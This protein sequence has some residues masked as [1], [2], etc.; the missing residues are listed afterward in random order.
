M[1]PSRTNLIGYSEY[2]N[3]SGWVIVSSGTI[4]DNVDTSPEGVVN[5]FS[6]ETTTFGALRYN[7]TLATSTTYTFSFYAKNVDATRA[8][9]Y[10]VFNNDTATDLVPQTSYL[11]Q[12]STTEW[13]RISLTFTTNAT[14]TGYSVYVTSGNQEGTILFYGAQ[15][16]QGS[17]PTSYIHYDRDW[18]T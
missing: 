3:G 6:F 10:R 1:E 9:N 4:V 8:A 11:S 5:A 16:E 7:V 17:Y 18:E 2:A 12:L 13:K 14:N 15:L